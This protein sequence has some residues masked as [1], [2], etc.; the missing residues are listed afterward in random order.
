[1]PIAFKFVPLETVGLNTAFAYMGL[2]M[3]MPNP[4]TPGDLID[5][6]IMNSGSHI[7]IIGGNTRNRARLIEDMLGW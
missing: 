6:A 2:K 4:L 5:L 7:L 3:S 1:M